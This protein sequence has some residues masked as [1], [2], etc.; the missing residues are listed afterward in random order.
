MKN[1]FA[2]F[3]ILI[4]FC[5]LQ[6]SSFLDARPDQSLVVP[7]S[8]ADLQALLDNDRIMNGTNGLG[9]TPSLG[10]AACTDYYINEDDLWLSFAFGK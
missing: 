10:E 7:S 9:V 2:I 3:C 5:S 1:V 6:K 4:F 8:L